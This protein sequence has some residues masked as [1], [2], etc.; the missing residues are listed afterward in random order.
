MF[1]VVLAGFSK[2]CS[3]WFHAHGFGGLGLAGPVGM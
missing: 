2:I 3:V 1:F